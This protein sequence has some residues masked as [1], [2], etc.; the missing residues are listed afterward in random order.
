[1]KPP[2]ASQRWTLQIFGPCMLWI[3]VPCTLWTVVSCT[4]WI[5]DFTLSVTSC[6]KSVPRRHMVRFKR[7]MISWSLHQA[8]VHSS[9]R[10]ACLI[11]WTTWPPGWVL[12]VWWCHCVISYELSRDLMSFRRTFMACS[13]GILHRGSVNIEPSI[14]RSTGSASG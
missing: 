6:D 2:G 11:W 3:L 7:W 13:S 1:M 12:V 4:P 14:P 8:W 5:I 9:A 10:R